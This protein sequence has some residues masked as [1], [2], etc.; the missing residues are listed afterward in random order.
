MNKSLPTS[1]VL[2]CVFTR[3]IFLHDVKW[4]AF[5][6]VKFQNFTQSSTLLFQS[7][8]LRDFCL[9]EINLATISA[10]APRMSLFPWQQLHELG[11][12]QKSFP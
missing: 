2:F 10:V 3:F 11:K 9:Q 7:T 8:V 4:L 5:P 6:W 1:E 12:D